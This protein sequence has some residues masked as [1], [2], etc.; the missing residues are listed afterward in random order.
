MTPERWEKIGQLYTSALEVA[1]DERAAFL[2]EACAGDEELR[3]EVESLIAAD[4]QAGDFIAAP[5]FGNSVDTLT[6]ENIRSLVGRRFG[7][8]EVLAF[9][10]RG[11]MGE[12]YLAEDKRLLTFARLNRI[13]SR[14]T[15]GAS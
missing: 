14:R 5:V 7:D 11:G 4:A 15:I 13:Y 6:E 9:L 1:P 10:G 8:Y 3:R 12:V 2:E